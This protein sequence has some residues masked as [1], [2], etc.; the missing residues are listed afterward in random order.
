[1]VRTMLR[2]NV[3]W[4]QL[5]ALA[6][7]EQYSFDFSNA[8]SPVLAQQGVPLLT[9]M[10]I[11]PAEDPCYYEGPYL[12]CN[13]GFEVGNEVNLTTVTFQARCDI[14]PTVAFDYRKASG[15]ICQAIVTNPLSPGGGGAKTCPC[16]ICQAGFGDTPINV[17][18]SSLGGSGNEETSEMTASNATMLAASNET[19]PASN[20][21]VSDSVALPATRHVGRRRRLQNDTTAPPN[22][23]YIFDTCTSVDCSGACNGTCALNCDT[24]GAACSYC[25]TVPTLA[26]TPA[27]R[28]EP[29][30]NFSAA[31]GPVVYQ[32]CGFPVVW[33]AVVT[34][35]AAMLV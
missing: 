26:P 1:M 21:T 23:P 32:Y 12:V 35:V 27:K 18:C 17:D 13:Y 9:R 19:M 30:K 20:D 5:L 11:D 28:G 22:D 29:V 6:S 31:A 2:F 4:L 15:C 3:I 8:K 7:A 33:M 34:L 16:T 14:D 10:L 25:E 24:S